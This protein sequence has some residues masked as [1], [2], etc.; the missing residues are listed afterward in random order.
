[1]LKNL[2]ASEEVDV[3]GVMENKIS[4]VGYFDRG[5]C[6]KPKKYSSAFDVYTSGAVAKRMFAH[7]RLLS[8][9]ES[10]KQ[11]SKRSACSALFL[12][13]SVGAPVGKDDGTGG[14]FEA[15]FPC[16]VKVRLGMS[17]GSGV[18]SGISEDAGVCF[19][20]MTG[21]GR[22]STRKL[23]FEGRSVGPGNFDRG[24][25]SGGEASAE[26]GGPGGTVGGSEGLSYLI[27]EGLSRTLGGVV[28]FSA[29]A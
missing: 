1:M 10:E 20:G 23:G 2:W 7:G 5:S 14:D 25:K 6:I 9:G 26:A 12:S 22:E 4:A 28:S 15:R 17:E 24:P 13:R 29:G 11:S 8:R 19:G 3:M 18:G 16:R 21:A 27:G